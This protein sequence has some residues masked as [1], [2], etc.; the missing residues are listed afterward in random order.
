MDFD[1]QNVYSMVN[2]DEIKVGTMGFYGDDLHALREYVSTNN[3]RFCGIVSKI[4][5]DT[6]GRRFTMDGLESWALFYPIE[7]IDN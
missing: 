2:A 3:R 1:K 5:P 6:W 4:R 7:D